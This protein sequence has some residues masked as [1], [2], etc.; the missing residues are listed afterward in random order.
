MVKGYGSLLHAG[1][2]FWEQEA[3]IGAWWVLSCRTAAEDWESV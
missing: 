3:F 2:M 1:E